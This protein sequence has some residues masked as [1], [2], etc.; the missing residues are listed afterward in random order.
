MRR[1]L[2]INPNTSIGVGNTID[3]LVRAETAGV[4]D[5]RTVTA[6]FGF[7]YISTRVA[8]S[9]AAHAVLDAAARAIAEGAAPDAILL[10]CFGDP[11]R[12]ALAEM[13]RLPVVG[14]A[15][16][17]LLA[18]VDL[19]GTSLVAT[20]GTVWCEMLSEL[21]LKLGIGDRIAGIRSIEDVADEPTAVAA[22]LA[23]EAEALGA[24]RIVLG[25]AGLIPSLPEVAELS[26]VP[27]LTRIA[28][29]SARRCDWPA[30]RARQLSGPR[31]PARPPACR[32]TSQGCWAVRPPRFDAWP[33][34]AKRQQWEPIW[35]RTASFSNRIQN[36]YRLSAIV[37]S[38]VSVNLC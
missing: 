20:N 28:S 4:A 24:E 13:T 14:F 25:G 12:E 17:G 8:V 29:P 5:V 33:A 2:V 18:A 27:I 30:C 34:A 36:T 35:R 7:S 32:R 19:P 37:F 6:D 11:G 3:A 1:L 31:P 10:A 16:A 26:P 15:E 23:G 38:I 9:I 22:F 21:V